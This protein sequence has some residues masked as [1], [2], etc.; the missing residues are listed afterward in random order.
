MN[1]RKM[2]LGL[3]LLTTAI[4]STGCAANKMKDRISLLEDAN[5]TLTHQLNSMQGEMDGCFRDRDLAYKQLT[6]ANGELDELRFQ[7]AAIPAD[8]PAAPGWTAV[9]GGAMIAIDG[10][11]LFAVGQTVLRSEAKRTLDAVVS[12]LESQYA[13]KDIFVFGH[14]DNQPIK[15]SGWDDNWQLSSE[16]SLAVVRYLSERGV[17]SKRLVACGAGDNR[18]VSDNNS[19]SGRSSNRRVEIFAIDPNLA[20]GHR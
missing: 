11:V 18:P 19:A 3:A 4:G 9:P 16:R 8:E 14:T 1:I 20:T 5:R 7:L 17:T 10:R 2:G 13:D 15:K 6:N 12:T